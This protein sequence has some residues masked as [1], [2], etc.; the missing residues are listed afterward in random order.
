MSRAIFI[1]FLIS[2]FSAGS[3]AQLKQ[4][5]EKESQLQQKFIE[6]NTEFLIGRYDQ[7]EKK[8]IEIVKENEAIAAVHFELGKVYEAK[9]D[10]QRALGSYS[11]AIVLDK[12]NKWYY[13]QKIKLLDK[14]GSHAEAATVCEQLTQVDQITADH[15]YDWAYHA[16]QAN[17]PELAITALDKLEAKQGPNINIAEKKLRIFQTMGQPDRIRSTI[18]NLL[19]VS[20]DCI[21]CLTMKAN[22]YASS[23]KPE[24][25]NKVWERILALDSA[26]T[27]AKIA[28]AAGKKAI[29]DDVGFIESIKP[30]FVNKNVPFDSKMK[31]LLPY[32][33]KLSDTHDP[34]LGESLMGALKMLDETNPDNPKTKAAMADVARNTGWIKEAAALYKTCLDLD[35]NVYAVWEQRLYTLDQIRDYPEMLKTSNDLF[36]LFP[37]IAMATYWNALA[38]I[39]NNKPDDAIKIIESGMAAAKKNPA[40]QY[41]LTILTGMAW[42][43]KKDLIRSQEAFKTAQTLNPAVDWAYYAEAR[44]L[45][46]LSESYNNA[47]EL[48]EKAIK[49][50]MGSFVPIA[51]EAYVLMKNNN[52]EK[53]KGLYEEAINKGAADFPE[54]LEEYGDLLYKMNDLKSAV[55]YWQMSLDKG[56][57]IPELRKKLDAVKL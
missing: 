3:F 11:R 23:N 34:R 49:N 50:S 29:G 18:D 38:L 35:K 37:G 39:R 47:L 19:A 43:Q 26:N 24:E 28:L 45:S 53:S 27:D 13:I 55:K 4:I 22:Y 12:S 44:V 41:K 15:Y 56:I 36:D 51:V 30:L 46:D 57:E 2:N 40:L 16:I 9:G 7:A 32:I 17:N 42:G 10:D 20:P 14:A 52:F 1:I 31:E 5:T 6:A 54:I 21:P 48:C 33:Q 8:L 25:A